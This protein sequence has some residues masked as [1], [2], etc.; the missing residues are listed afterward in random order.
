MCFF[1]YFSNSDESQQISW[2][3]EIFLCRYRKNEKQFEVFAYV[4]RSLN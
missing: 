2:Q 4:N 1:D 3:I